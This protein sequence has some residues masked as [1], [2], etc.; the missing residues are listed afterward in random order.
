MSQIGIPYEPKLIVP[1]SRVYPIDQ[2]FRS[3]IKPRVL[4]KLTR[5]SLIALE[6]HRLWHVENETFVNMDK[7]DLHIQ[8]IGEAMLHGASFIEAHHFAVDFMKTIR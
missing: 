6:E 5:S 7:L 2:T 1:S 8:V 4:Q 3:G